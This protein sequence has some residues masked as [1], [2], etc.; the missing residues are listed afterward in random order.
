VAQFQAYDNPDKLGRKSYPFLLDIQS[1]LIGDSISTIVIPLAPA[2]GLQIPISRLNPLVKIDGVEYFV[3]T[4]QI[5]GF[6]RKDLGKP[7]ADLGSYR[8][9]IVSAI[10]FVIS[11]F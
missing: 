8:H 11:G 9:E 2:K 3:I 1:N 4:Q 6:E 10:D 5:S 7:K